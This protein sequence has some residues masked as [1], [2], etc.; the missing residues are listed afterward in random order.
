M[1]LVQVEIGPSPRGH[2]R[3]RLS[4]E[5]SYRTAGRPTERLW[6]D[7]AES[8]APDLSHSG[9]PWLAALLPLAVTLGEP[10][11]LVRPVDAMLREGVEAL[12]RVWSVWYPA[13]Y[14]PI[15]IECDVAQR[16][17]PAFAARIATL[18]SAGVDSFY[19]LLRHEPGGAA[20]D[21]LRIDDLLTIWGFDVPLQA[22]EAF[23]QLAASIAEV[24]QAL[25]KTPVT[26]AT[27]LRESGWNAA[28]W[29]KIAQGPAIAAAALA[30]EGRYRQVLIPSS[31]TFRT[32]RPWGSHPMTDPL[33]SSSRTEIRDD[34]ALARRPEKMRSLLG[35]ELALE[36][37][38]VC[39]MSQS[40]AN[41][42]VCEKCLRTLTILELL[43]AR[44]RAAT[45]PSDTWSLNAIANLRLR[46]DL[47]RQAMKRMTQVARDYGRADIV[48]AAT[49]A[50]R[51]YDL[52]KRA[53]RLARALGFR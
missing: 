47:D 17:T 49:R 6:F 21:K 15:P 26:I 51:R 46:Q 8:L 10:L 41:C 42:G 4:G 30:L 19:T 53:G 20:Y 24:A 9:N 43:G 12:M 7:V 31:I 16:G 23:R 18:F 32:L 36:H 50:V 34:G 13:D 35:S 29:G 1:K 44:D 11:E 3:I 33:L 22:A 27:N 28:N 5:I 38:H 2:G 52:R 14:Q 37:L 39:W 40:A 48:R 25:G 45:F